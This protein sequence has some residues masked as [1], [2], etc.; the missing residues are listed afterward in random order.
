[1]GRSR[2]TSARRIVVAVILSGLLA[3]ASSA[4]ALAGSTG[5]PWPK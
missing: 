1:M 5:G 2:I 4:V 3:I